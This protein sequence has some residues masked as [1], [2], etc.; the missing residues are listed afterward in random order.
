MES[1]LPTFGYARVSSDSQSLDLQLAQLRTA[2][3][4]KMFQ[5][6]IS[7]ARSD[8]KE[9]AKLMAKLGNGDCVIVCRLDRLA[10]SSRDLLNILHEIAVKKATFRS[11][12]DPWADTT[13]PHGRLMLTVLGGLAEFERSLIRARTS[14]GR[15]RAMANGIRFGRKPK[16]TAHQRKEARQRRLAGESLIAIARSYNVSH[17]TIHRLLEV[18]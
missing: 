4:E 18:G 1:V 12:H 5:E 11:L 8:R 3:C 13:T 14:E 15:K 10:R 9:L 2:G 7:G 16:L 6:K 17:S